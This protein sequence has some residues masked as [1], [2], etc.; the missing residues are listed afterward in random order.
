MP[1][2]LPQKCNER[3]CYKRTTAK[4]G[5]CDVHESENS[6]KARERAY[7]K[8][9]QSDATHQMYLDPRFGWEAFR[10]MLQMQGNVIC[11]RII[12]GLRCT[13]DVVIFH[14]LVSPR[15]RPELFTVPSNVV[16]VCREHHPI[17]EGTPDWRPGVDFVETQY[18]VPTF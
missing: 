3:G 15:V 12:A 11:Q 13:A 1:N 6:V 4:S 17:T 2:R 7:H 16:G 10:A 5:Y 18:K 14:H 8:A 9:R